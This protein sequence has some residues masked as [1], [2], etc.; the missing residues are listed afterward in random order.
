MD[1]HKDILVGSKFI[2]DTTLKY[3]YSKIENKHEVSIYD[4]PD[5]I[6]KE[7]LYNELRCADLDSY[8]D[9]V[10]AEYLWRQYVDIHTSFNNEFGFTKLPL[11][12]EIP[13]QDVLKHEPIR[14]SR[15]LHNRTEIL[16]MGGKSKKKCRS[17]SMSSYFTRNHKRKSVRRRTL[18]RKGMRTRKNVRRVQRGGF[19]GN[20]EN[21]G[22]VIDE[23]NDL[24]CSPEWDGGFSKMVK[25]NNINDNP[26]FLYGSSLPRKNYRSGHHDLSHRQCTNLLNFYRFIM[27]IP[28]IISL[29]GCDLDWSLVDPS[30]ELQ[31]CK[32][33]NELT[34]WNEVCDRYNQPNDTGEIVEEETNPS[35]MVEL[36]WKDF[37]PGY[38]NT[39]DYLSKIDFTQKRNKSIMHCLA[40][41][42][43]TGTALLLVICINYY[44]TERKFNTDFG[45]NPRESS[46]KLNINSAKMVKKFKWLLTSHLVNES[47]IPSNF[48]DDLEIKPDI[49]R[50]IKSNVSNFDI[51]KITDE[52]F[53]NHYEPYAGYQPS[54]TQINTFI[55]RINYIIYFTA[56]RNGI[57]RF[58]LFA[59]KT[60]NY[61]DGK[62]I[63]GPD[64]LFQYLLNQPTIYTLED[65]SQIME[66][67][68]TYGFDLYDLPILEGVVF[69]LLPEIDR[70]VSSNSSHNCIVS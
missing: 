34:I 16:G 54:Y 47:N 6:T 40:G 69:S 68:D 29:Q 21:L 45:V 55:T 66:N 9:K 50:G 52:I 33:V 10:T 43:R 4:I 51:N 8:Y 56:L 44:N 22:A 61:F 18:R 24:N 59:L 27:D 25:I 60:K 11:K 1:K 13:H 31:S 36:Y 23:I 20:K 48:H 58:P 65:V 5:G 37:H 2:I 17:S 70:S 3:F 14:M 19:N 39:F 64:T 46:V 32:G 7:M 57:R 26:I 49:I 12:L 63:D 30:Y 62:R 53:L 67:P 42:G 15:Y 38:F 41:Y 28:N 35:N